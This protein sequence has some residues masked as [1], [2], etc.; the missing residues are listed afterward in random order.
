MTSRWG[1]ITPPN[2]ERS[3]RP[4]CDTLNAARERSH[5]DLDVLVA[6]LKEKRSWVID[7]RTQVRDQG[8]ERFG[9]GLE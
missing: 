2:W 1:V 9:K 7:E 5:P 8:E 6:L 3:H 4:V